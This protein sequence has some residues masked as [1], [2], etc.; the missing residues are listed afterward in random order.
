MG[1]CEIETARRTRDVALGSNTSATEDPST[2]NLE[3]DV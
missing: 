3:G 2:P 1:C